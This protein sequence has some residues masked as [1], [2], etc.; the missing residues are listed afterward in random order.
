[1]VSW[2]PNSPST[3]I[4]YG[5][6]RPL[7]ASERSPEHTDGHC[8]IACRTSQFTSVLGSHGS[9]CARS[10]SL[11]RLHCAP[12]RSRTGRSSHHTGGHPQRPGGHRPARVGGGIER[13]RFMTGPG[14]SLSRAGPGTR[15]RRSRRC[16]SASASLGIDHQTVR[17][18]QRREQM[19]RRA[20][21]AAERLHE[22]LAGV[23]VAHQLAA[24]VPLA[25]GHRGDRRQRA[26]LH[27]PSHRLALAQRQP[28]QRPHHHLE[29]H[30]RADRV[31]GQQK[32]RHTLAARA[33]RS[34]APNRDA[35]R[36]GSLP[37]RRS[38][39]AP[40]E[41]S[42]RPPRRRRRRSPPPRR[43]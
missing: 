37:S 41:R 2:P 6:I 4:T 24:Q 3:S 34:P 11:M 1:M 31:G 42:R 14:S 18:G 20:R 36:C 39:R 13:H 21:R 5:S 15:R 33:G 43:D 40:R 12:S 22:V 29:H 19:R 32:H 23:L 38:R 30:Q 26:G 8:E 7:R 9:R 25:A 16:G 10:A 17:L 35:S 27:D 28:D